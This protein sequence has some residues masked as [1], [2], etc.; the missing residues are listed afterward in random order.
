MIA[1]AEFNTGGTRYIGKNPC[2]LTRTAMLKEMFPDA[3]F[4]F[5]HRH[6]YNVI[7]S[8]YHFILSVFPGVQLQDVPPDFSREKV[9]ILYSKVMKAYFHD[10]GRIPSSDLIELK[11]D[12]FLGDI[13]GHMKEV[14]HKFGMGDFGRVSPYIEKYIAENPRPVHK[15]HPPGPE[16]TRL[17]DQYASEI[18]LQL[19]YHGV[20]PEISSS[21]KPT[22]HSN[23]T[24]QYS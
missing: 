16:T 2:H 1:K 3:K 9:A 7:E 13:T 17:V 20:T 21:Q 15:V 11:M 5:I 6:P 14:Y 10:R 23:Q 8:L 12:D 19:G 24:L 22:D 18:M 4:I